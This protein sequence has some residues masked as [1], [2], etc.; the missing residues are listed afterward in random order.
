MCVVTV[1]T[2]MS[3]FTGDF[4]YFQNPISHWCLITG[5]M[6]VKM[7][8]SASA[9]PWSAWLGPAHSC[10]SFFAVKSAFLETES[11]QPALRALDSSAHHLSHVHQSQQT[12]LPSWDETTERAA[13]FSEFAPEDRPEW[14]PSNWVLKDR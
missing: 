5:V 4:P 1:R 9:G 8:Q 13:L 14:V 11:F 6:M 10:C 2:C 7:M 3:C 12:L